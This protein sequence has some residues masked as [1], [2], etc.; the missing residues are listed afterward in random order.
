MVV[1][2][3]YAQAWDEESRAPWR[4]I[5][6]AEPWER[7]VVGLPYAVVYRQPG[8]ETVLEVRL[9]SW[10]DHYVGLRVHDAQGRRTHDLDMRLLDDPSRLLRRYSVS[11][12]YTGSEMVEFDD[13]CPRVTVDLFPDGRGR[14]TEERQ[15]RRG[16]SCVTSPRLRDEEC[17]MER[18][19]FGEWPL[20]SARAHGFIDPPSFKEAEA[21]GSAEP[22]GDE[23]APAT[24]WRPPC[25]AQPGPIGELFRRGVRVTDGYHP[26]QTVVE[27]R[28]VGT[29]RVPS[30]MLAVSGPDID[31]GDGPHL[32]IPVQPGEYVLDEARVRFSYHCMWEEAEVTTTDPTAVRLF[33]SETAAAT[34]EMA[35]RP[36]DDPRLFIEHQIAGFDTDSATGCFADAGAWEP[37][38]ALFKRGLIQGESDTDGF[39]Y[40]GDDSMFMQHTWDKASGADLMS[41]AT[42]GDGTHPAWVGR[43]E[44]AGEVVAVV[45]LVEGMPECLPERDGA[46]ADG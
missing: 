7:D 32:T 34:W 46:N 5:S 10:R 26:E 23:D 19:A 18:P 31:R 44:E 8:R 38:T 45:V 3:E 12:H 35:L 29:L 33:L 11:W 27:P 28:R 4:P 25:P 41:F 37:L 9:V 17:W 16:G 39:E 13:A 36:T 43:S 20:L 40:L 24:C 21:A 30:G 6:G 2:V 42:T 22:E 14:R 15:G 1:E